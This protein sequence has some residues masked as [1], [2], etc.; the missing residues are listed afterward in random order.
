MSFS[1]ALKNGD[2]GLSGTS[3]GTVVDAAKLQ[4]DLVCAILTPLGF[5]ELHP[6]FG[7]ILEEDLINPEV[8]IIGSKDFQHAAALIRSELTRLCQNYQAQQIAR[9]ESDAVRFGKPTLTPGEILLQVLSIK[10]VQA[11]D[12]LLCTLQ[13]EIGNDSIELNIPMST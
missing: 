5:E 2:L 8:Q 13:L 1:L 9:N 6:E 11:E 12:H 3:L 7:S 10:F 4:Q